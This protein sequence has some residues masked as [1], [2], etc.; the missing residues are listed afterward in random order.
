MEVPRWAWLAGSPKL[1]AEIQSGPLQEHC[2]TKQTC[3]GR[4]CIPELQAAKPEASTDPN[5]AA[6]R[7]QTGTASSSAPGAG[8]QSAQ[9]A[10]AGGSQASGH[11]QRQRSEQQQAGS[12]GAG[13]QQ[14]AQQQAAAAR[15]G[16]SRLWAAARNEVK[17][18]VHAVSCL[19]SALL[20]PSPAWVEALHT[21]SAELQG[22]V[23]CIVHLAVQFC[24]H[25]AVH[26]CMLADSKCS[27]HAQ[28]GEVQ[29]VS[30][31]RGC[32]DL[33]WESGSLCMPV[34]SAARACRWM[35]R[36]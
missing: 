32:R 35:Q 11:Q 3:S 12:A 4:S 9:G 26:P 7:D 22:C 33:H 8:A 19:P 30:S 17:H 29:L 36:R 21:C 28:L 14:G 18:V 6:A 15:G 31:L 5:S 24:C 23:K 2:S 1:P 16:L 10:Q 34:G 27:R 20:T 25:P 13:A